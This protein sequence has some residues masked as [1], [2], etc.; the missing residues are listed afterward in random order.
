MSDIKYGDASLKARE[1]FSNKVKTQLNKNVTDYGK[2]FIK[3]TSEIPNWET[4]LTPKQLEVAI[5]YLKTMNA[6]EIDWQLK[7]T[8]GTTHQR[9]FGS[10][11]SKGAIGRLEEVY[12]MLENNGFYTEKQK[13]QETKK[14]EVKKVKLTKKSLGKVRELFMLINT[15]PHYEKHLTNSQIEKVDALLK[16]RSFVK[17][18]KMCGVTTLSYQQSLIGKKGVLDTLIKAQNEQTVSSWEEI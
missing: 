1:Y 10:K 6:H 9:L 3:L 18:A 12:K 16:T 17:G 13:L 14:T 4:Y 5:R 15:V 11:T 2:R 7:L 8:S